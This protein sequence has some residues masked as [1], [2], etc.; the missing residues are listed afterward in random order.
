MS[1]FINAT[2]DDHKFDA[3]I[4]V[5]NDHAV[6]CLIEALYEQRENIRACRAFCLRNG[7]KYPGT[8]TIY[9]NE[10]L[11]R[12]I[13]DKF[14]TKGHQ[15]KKAATKKPT[16]A[17]V[18]DAK[19]AKKSTDERQYSFRTISIDKILNG[20][21]VRAVNDISDLVAVL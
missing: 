21:N 16:T 15:M 2:I 8:R 3:L 10:R 11:I 20:D 4:E 6:H 5:M 17:S 7:H 14:S 19:P 9:E 13:D 1:N 18:K 12:S